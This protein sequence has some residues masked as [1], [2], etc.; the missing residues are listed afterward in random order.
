LQSVGQ[1][2]DHGHAVHF[3]G[4]MC[5]IYDKLENKKELMV[6]MNMKRNRNFPLTLRPA[7]DVALKI[8]V[9]NLSWL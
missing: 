3:E 6:V 4:V 8:D 1:L 9:R 5:K 2:I 7:R